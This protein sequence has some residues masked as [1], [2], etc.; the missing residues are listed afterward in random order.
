MLIGTILSLVFAALQFAGLFLARDF[1]AEV[2]DDTA[3]R[4]EELVG[5]R[6]KRAQFAALPETGV[7]LLDAAYWKDVL[8][9]FELSG[10]QRSRVE[11]I[12][13][14]RKS[15]LVVLVLFS[16]AIVRSVVLQSWW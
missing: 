13:F 7:F 14:L 8:S 12:I 16:L 4:L 2:N 9:E 1:R 15:Q 11:R 5:S 3:R 10:R 6:R